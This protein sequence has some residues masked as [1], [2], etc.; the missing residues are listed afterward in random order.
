MMDDFVTTPYF[1]TVT[2]FDKAFVRVI[3]NAYHKCWKDNEKGMMIMTT[4]QM[5]K[6]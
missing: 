3:M 2:S 1:A 6:E 4:S 5:N